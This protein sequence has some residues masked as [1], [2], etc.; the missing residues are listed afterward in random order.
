M[1]AKIE[2]LKKT[3][4]KKILT[5]EDVSSVRQCLEKCERKYLLAWTD[6]GGYD[7]LHHAIMANNIEAVG[8][9]FAMGLFKPPHEPKYHPYIHLAANFGNR[10]ISVMILQERP[11][12]YSTTRTKFKW[13]KKPTESSQNLTSETSMVTPLDVAGECGHVDCIRSILDV[14]SIRTKLGIKGSDNH[15]SA[16][17]ASSSS[18]ALRL[19]LKQRPSSEDIKSAIGTALKQANAE[20][21]DVLLKCNT[22]LTSLFGGMNLYHVLYSYC[23]SFKKTWY[24]S[25]LAVTSV[26]LKHKQNPVCAI[27]FRTYPLY[28]LISHTPASDFGRTFPY[29]AACMVVLLNAGVDPNFNEVHFESEHEGKNVQTAFGRGA[30][31]SALH[32]LYGNVK[33]LMRRFDDEDTNIR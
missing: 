21:L 9:I 3:L 28:S 1:A 29:I 16:A 8:M 33:T 12:D 10:S 23:F 19:L 2:D 15:L 17:C 4:Y 7:V 13:V 24:E 27:P 11:Q 6:E 25:F 5:T 30:F 31:P 32:C 14:S 20:C 26:L 22:S 18:S